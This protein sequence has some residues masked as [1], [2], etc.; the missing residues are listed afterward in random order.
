MH[1]SERIA[2]LPHSYQVND[3]RRPIAPHA[4]S[5]AQ[6][7][8]P[9]HRFVF[10]SFNNFYKITPEVFGVW[11]RLLQKVDGSVLWLLDH[12]PTAT[13][14]L[15]AEAHRRGI[16]PGR[17]VFAPRVVP[18]AHLARHRLADLFLDT[19]Y[20]NAHT[21]AA[22]AL[23]AGV[24][25]LTRPGN[26][27]AGRV[28]ASLLHAIGMPEMIANSLAEYEAL[29]LRLARDPALL[30]ETKA[31]L[32]RNRTA[33]ALFDTKRFTRNLEAAYVRM[34]DNVISSMPRRDP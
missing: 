15:R 20:C 9:E 28:A 34:R 4:P 23:W 12:N 24:P 6:A 1:Y 27:F 16:V 25:V 18:P 5:R 21:T 13:R 22:D 33:Q 29:A 7:G 32:A 11:M 17:L 30:A 31:K 19:F 10:C 3:S 2:W 8:L 14:N 26:T